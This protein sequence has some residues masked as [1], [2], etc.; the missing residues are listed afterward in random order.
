MVIGCRRCILCSRGRNRAASPLSPLLR[1]VSNRSGA[2]GRQASRSRSRSGGGGLYSCGIAAGRVDSHRRSCSRASVHRSVFVAVPRRTVAQLGT[3]TAIFLIDRC[4][5]G[6][7]LCHDGACCVITPSKATA[8]MT[9]ALTIAA[10]DASTAD[11]PS[12]AGSAASP[13][14]SAPL[15]ANSDHSDDAEF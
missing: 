14:N 2:A 7:E 8:D 13:P 4:A 15:D 1:E 5:A 12:A 3:P 6:R 10:F 9:S 11:A